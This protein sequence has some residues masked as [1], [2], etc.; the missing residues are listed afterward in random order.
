MRLGRA[1]ERVKLLSLDDLDRRTSAYQRTVRLLEALE[2]DAG[3]HDQLSTGQ[4][5]LARRAAVH[6]ALLEDI[7]VRWL[8]GQEID[9]STY[10]LLT[11][12]QRRLLEGIGL[13]RQ[14]KELNP[15]DREVIDIYEQEVSA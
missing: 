4:R 1:G 8:K 11:N 9:P 15:I 12:S 10:T 13:K 5:Q 3:G 7:E 14:P 2:V 6:G